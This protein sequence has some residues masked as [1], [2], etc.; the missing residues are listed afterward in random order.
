MTRTQFRILNS[1][2]GL[3]AALIL[4][5]LAMSTSN[6][7]LNRSVA[8]T[9]GRFTQA[10]QIQNTTQSLV[11]RVAQAGQ[12]EPV[13]RELLLRHN[14]TVDLNSGIPPKATP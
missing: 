14:F 7:T 12:N 8:T 2:G 13:L 6:G 10:Q 3:C 4:A 1:I 11:Q 5:N 9:Q